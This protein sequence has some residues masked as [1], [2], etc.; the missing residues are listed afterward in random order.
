MSS[1]H[2]ERTV[3]GKLLYP[4][5]RKMPFMTCLSLSVEATHEQLAVL[6]GKGT[7]VHEQ[8]INGSLLS[9]LAQS[10][11]ILSHNHKCTGDTIL[12]PLF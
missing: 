5:G 4:L 3:T 9:L 10:S 6:Q 7:A 8:W 12:L 2:N 1:V 11:E